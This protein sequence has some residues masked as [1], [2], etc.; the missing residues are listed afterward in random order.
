MGPDM[1][2]SR[3]PCRG[4]TTIAISPPPGSPL[5]EPDRDLP[6][7]SDVDADHAALKAAGLDVDGEVT[8]RDPVPP[9][10]WL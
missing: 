8:L 9:M 3:S 4:T 1:R 5:A 6:D 10:F 7:T 2:W